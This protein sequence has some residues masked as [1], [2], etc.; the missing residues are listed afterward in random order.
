MPIPV[1][2]SAY[3]DGTGPS[4]YENKI[5]LKVKNDSA[6]AAA[7]SRA[8]VQNM[9]Q[10]SV[11]PTGAAAAKPSVLG[12]TAGPEDADFDKDNIVKL[13]FNKFDT[14]EWKLNSINITNL[15]DIVKCYCIYSK[16][17]F[18]QD[19][20]ISLNFH[21]RVRHRYYKIS[22]HLESLPHA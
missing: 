9:A 3:N 13:M 2:T 6:A 21:N 4:A 12:G 1:S 14:I 19:V 16:T 11:D 20:L 22:L 17:F 15:I 8:T 5:M 7:E 18:H 10:G